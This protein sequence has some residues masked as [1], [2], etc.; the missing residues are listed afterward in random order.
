MAENHSLLPLGV[1]TTE[2]IAKKTKLSVGSI[3]VMVSRAR[4]RRKQGR[5]LPTD[6]PLADFIAFRF[7]LWRI[8]T[9]DEWIAV[10]K[11]HHLTG[12]VPA[13][14]AKPVAKTET[15]PAK[16]VSV[17]TAKTETKTVKKAPKKAPV[18]PVKKSTKK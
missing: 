10:R 1:M 5:A 15:K 4:K 3:R 9:V 18:K 13:K 8:E 17:K 12:K 2:D 14:K 7:P 6:I 16:K 11:E